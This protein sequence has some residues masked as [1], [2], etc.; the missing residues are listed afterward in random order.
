MVMISL[1]VKETWTINDIERSRKYI[2]KL[3]NSTPHSVHSF[4]Y[5]I[6]YVSAVLTVLRAV[7]SR[8]AFLN[9]Q[10]SIVKA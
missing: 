4:I 8:R 5:H 1:D 10:N 6:A 7:P 2:Y 3:K 9:K